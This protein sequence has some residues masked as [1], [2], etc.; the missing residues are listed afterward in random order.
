MSDAYDNS[1]VKLGIRAKSSYD[2]SILIYI[3]IYITNIIA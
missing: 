3:Y 1:C 2:N